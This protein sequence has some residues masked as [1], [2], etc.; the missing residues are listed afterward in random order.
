VGGYW[1]AGDVAGGLMCA[2]STPTNLRSS[3]LSVQPAISGLASLLATG[4]GLVL[5]NILGDSSAG[6]ISLA[7]AVPGTVIGLVIFVLKARETKH[8]DLQEVTGGEA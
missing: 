5:I 4:V 8:V 6:L 7:L 3:V 1:A 2:E